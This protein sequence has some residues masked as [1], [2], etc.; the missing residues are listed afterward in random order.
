M[1][2][3]EVEYI[4]LLQE[5]TISPPIGFT[6]GGNVVVVDVEEEEEQGVFDIETPMVPDI[7]IEE[8]EVDVVVD[9]EFDIGAESGNL[10]D[11]DEEFD[12]V[13]IN[14][15]IPIPIPNG[16]SF[17]VYSQVFD[18]E[19]VSELKSL[20]DRN[21]IEDV[22]TRSTFEAWRVLE[23]SPYTQSFSFLFL[24]TKSGS[25]SSYFRLFDVM[26][27]VISKTNGYAAELEVIDDTD[28]STL[29]SVLLRR[30]TAQQIRD[31][32]MGDPSGDYAMQPL[33]PMCK[34]SSSLK[35]SAMTTFSSGTKPAIVDVQFA[36]ALGSGLVPG[37]KESFVKELSKYNIG[38]A[39]DIRAVFPV[40]WSVILESVA[41]VPP[42][43]LGLDEVSSF[44][45]QDNVR[46]VIDRE[47]G[48]FNHGELLSFISGIAMRYVLTKSNYNIMHHCTY[49]KFS[50]AT[51]WF[52]T[53]F[54]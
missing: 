54:L 51:S 49:L 12:E 50:H 23:E 18:R 46:V 3:G 1:K 10:A 42:T 52:S 40:S 15:Y 5:I 39:D 37:D 4:E 53:S 44:L 48:D 25:T 7:M 17:S 22:W 38:K 33:L 41:T 43:P 28:E 21:A 6:P 24:S 19:C 45:D 2:R 32:V 9:E 31:I 27:N 36:N 14:N 30:D 11:E 20:S 34:L 13:T 29:F 16:V 8:E 47:N 35:N 26:L